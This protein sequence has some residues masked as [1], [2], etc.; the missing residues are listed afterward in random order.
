MDPRIQ[1][2]PA[3]LPLPATLPAPRFLP[4]DF[5]EKKKILSLFGIQIKLPPTVS[6]P[7]RLTICSLSTPC[8]FPSPWSCPGLFLNRRS[9][10]CCVLPQHPLRNCLSLKRVIN[11]RDETLRA[12]GTSSQRHLHLLCVRK[13]T[14]DTEV[15]WA[16][17]AQPE[18]A[19]K[20]VAE[21]EAETRPANWKPQHTVQSLQLKQESI[22]P[23][24]TRWSFLCVENRFGLMAPGRKVT[25]AGNT[26]QV[27]EDPFTHHTCIE[28]SLVV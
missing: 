3:G 19:Q 21:G 2:L 9:G 5:N 17:G 14:L 28:P 26:N 7:S 10:E 25:E 13:L 18:R 15:S 20:C 23:P 22:Q 24:A 1:K 12:Q 6:H 4:G 16:S 11:R 8:P 27:V